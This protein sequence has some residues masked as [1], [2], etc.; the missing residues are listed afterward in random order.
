MKIS[1]K[2]V[3]EHFMLWMASLW[4][5]TCKKVAKEL[6]GIQI[7]IWGLSIV[8]L[9]CTLFAYLTYRGFV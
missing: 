9:L 5:K 4:E 3:D 2:V 7:A 1:I 8:I 6:I